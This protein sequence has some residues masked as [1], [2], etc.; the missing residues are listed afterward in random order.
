MYFGKNKR[1][2]FSALGFRK[3][4]IVGSE[5]R[6]SVYASKSEVICLI[7]MRILIVVKKTLVPSWM[8]M[9]MEKRWPEKV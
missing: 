5:L 6:Q 9:M 2:V 1:K 4:V 8:S 7:L 3:H